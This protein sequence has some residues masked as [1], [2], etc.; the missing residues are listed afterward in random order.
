[1]MGVLYTA[2]GERSDW[3]KVQ[4]ALRQGESVI[5]HPATAIMLEWADARL[6]EELE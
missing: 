6:R 1:M 5:I 2:N 3:G 4:V